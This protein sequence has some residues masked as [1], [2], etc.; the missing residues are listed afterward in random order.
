MN[1]EKETAVVN[2]GDKPY[3]KATRSSASR[4][5]K[6]NVV[7]FF[8]ILI[9]VA[10]VAAVVI[11]FIPGATKR[12]TATDETTI[13]FT[14]EFKGVDSVF[15]ANIKTGDTVYDSNGN[16]MLGTVKSVENY[17]Y[18]KLV[19]NEATGTAEMKEIPE[20]KNLVVTVTAKAIYTD[21]EGYSVNGDRIAVGC[22]YN[23]SFPHFSGSAYCIELSTVS[24]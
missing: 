18:E 8:L 20:L 6:F 23:I 1:N 10:I 14:L 9:V 15:V 22:N 5:G 16:Y 24:D 7:D 21:G 17:A 12:L 2:K 13:T 3:S 4:R 11:Y 19:Y